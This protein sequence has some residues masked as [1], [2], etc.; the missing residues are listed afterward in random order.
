MAP[1]ERLADTPVR[2]ALFRE[3]YRFSFFR[4]VGLLE[5][6]SPAKKPLGKALTPREE[7][8][9]FSVKQGLRFPPSDISDLRPPEEKGPATMEVAFM[10]LTGPSGVLPYWYTELAEERSRHRDRGLAAFLDLFHHRLLSLFYLAWKKY[11]LPESYLPGARDPISQG[12]L[13]L[14]GLGTPGIAELLGLPREGL[15]FYG[16]LLSRPAPCEAALGATVTYFARVPATI[17]QFID[18]MVPIDREDQTQVGLANSRL[19]VDALCGSMAWESQTKFRINLGPVGY[20]AFLRLLPS[21]ERLGVLFSLVRYMVGVEYDF[22]I[23][24]ILRKEEVPPCIVGLG[25]PE[26][27]RLGWSTWVKHPDFLHEEDPS[28]TFHEPEVRV[29]APP[30][31]VSWGAGG[32][33]PAGALN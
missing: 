4:A 9:R 22:E 21:G 25:T 16:G 30:A 28:V 14:I 24:L 8:V 3:F 32:E 17:D 7:P 13:S 31:R 5:Q 6:L 27:P 1:K 18:R 33:V 26:A 11:R 29:K 20:R 19:G 15:I 23:R 2:E 12:F 10:G